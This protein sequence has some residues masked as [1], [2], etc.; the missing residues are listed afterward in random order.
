MREAVEA[1][2]VEPLDAEGEVGAG[3]GVPARLGAAT[4]RSAATRRGSSAASA[5]SRGSSRRGSARQAQARCE[6]VTVVGDAGVGKS[7]L[8]AEALAA[9]EARVVR[10][11]CLPYGEGITYWPVVEVVKQLAVLPSDPVAAAA[12]RSLLGRV[13][14]RDERRRDRLGVPEAARGAGA[15]GRGLRRHPV[16]RGDVPRPGRV[17]GA[18]LDRMRRSC[19]SAWRGRSWS[20][21]APSW[22]GDAAAR[23]ARR[24]STRTR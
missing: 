14:G 5:S 21:G 23:A 19:S 10:G 6:L 12:I 16:G 18:A 8:V 4:R 20:S 2:P 13:G 17:D 22:P 1:E 24:R 9:V 7:R 11:R 3:G 15:A